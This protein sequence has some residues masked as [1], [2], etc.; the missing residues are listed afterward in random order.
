MIINWKKK[1]ELKPTLKSINERTDVIND[2]S[3]KNNGSFFVQFKD[4]QCYISSYDID[5]Y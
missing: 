2:V 4:F 5:L 1:Q 3:H